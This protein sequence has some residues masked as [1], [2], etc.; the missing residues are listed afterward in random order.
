MAKRT[1]T[2]FTVLLMVV[3]T[4][5]GQEAK[6]SDQASIVDSFKKMLQEQFEYENAD[7]GVSHATVVST[8][9]DAPAHAK[10]RMVHKDGTPCGA[11]HTGWCHWVWVDENGAQYLNNAGKPCDPAH[12]PAC[13]VPGK[14]PI[15]MWSKEYW[16]TVSDY[17]FDV[18]VTDSLVTPYVGVVTFKQVHWSTAKHATKEEAEADNNFARTLTAPVTHRYGYQDGQWK[19]LTVEAQEPHR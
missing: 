13:K 15:L 2:L 3:A 7:K 8:P 10:H 6:R 17:S 4:G 12:A 9:S 18:K 14:P 19:L 11:F 16:D 5:R 1:T